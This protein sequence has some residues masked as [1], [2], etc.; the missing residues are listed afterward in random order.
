MIYEI[1]IAP[2]FKLQANLK[3]ATIELPPPAPLHSNVVSGQ[4]YCR[5]LYDVRTFNKITY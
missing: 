5:T 4:F 1:P 3:D 2:K